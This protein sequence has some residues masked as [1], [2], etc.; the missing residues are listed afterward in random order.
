MLSPRQNNI[1]SVRRDA[2]VEVDLNCLEQNLKTIYSWL[3]DPDGLKPR[4]MAVVKSDA[5]GHGAPQIAEILV[6]LGVDGFGVASIDE[7]RQLRKAG[8]TAPVLILSPTPVWAQANALENDLDMTVTSTKQ[9][10][11]ILETARKLGKIEI[12]RAHV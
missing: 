1:A 7:G 9:V 11:D 8:I 2:W 4:L 6:A 3:Q 10:A 5:Y 12:G